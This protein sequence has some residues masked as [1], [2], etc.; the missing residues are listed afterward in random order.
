MHSRSRV[1]Q[2]VKTSVVDGLLR[3]PTWKVAGWS[4]FFVFVAARILVPSRS[5]GS[6]GL[7]VLGSDLL[8][9]LGQP[10]GVSTEALP[11]AILAALLLSLPIAGFTLAAGPFKKQLRNRQLRL[12]V[13]RTSRTEY[14]FGRVLGDSLLLGGVTALCSVLA[15]LNG[16]QRSDMLS[17]ETTLEPTL[18]LSVL[19]WSYGCLFLLSGYLLSLSARTSTWRM[20]W[21]TLTLCI[22]LLLPAALG[23]DLLS[24]LGHIAAVF[25]NVDPPLGRIVLTLWG[26]TGILAALGCFLFRRVEL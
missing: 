10:V 12:V 19:A 4:S 23:A 24:P 3:S 25:A 26:F 15:L 22:C 17:L 5:D 13:L 21:I 11:I 14:W 16:A 2:T 8:H 6:A 1:L 9:A 20:L 18:L 7:S